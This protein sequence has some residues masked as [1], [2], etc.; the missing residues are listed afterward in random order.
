MLASVASTKSIGD[1]LWIKVIGPP[2]T[3]KSSLCEALS[4]NKQYIVP[5]STIRGFHSGYKSP[6]SS[7]DNSLIPLIAN[8]TLV[9][10]D[11]DTMLQAPNKA[12]IFSEARDLYDRV[13]RAHYRTGDQKTYEGIPLTWILCG[14]NAL[15]EIDRSEL[16]ARFLDC[17]IMEPS[18]LLT[19]EG[20]EIED[21]ILWRAA[22]RAAEHVTI[23][24]DGELQ[25]Q[26]SGV[27]AIDRWLCKLVA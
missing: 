9:T 20:R 8:K 1:Q 17:I 18:W 14:T 22:N 24:S 10:K 2:S 21:D 25:S 15:R 7:K 27:H 13:S 26:H 3:A 4:I 5:I 11:G 6:G 19:D 12:Q 23:E 16:G